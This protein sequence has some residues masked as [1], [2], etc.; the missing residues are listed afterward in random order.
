[1]DKI[2]S[3]NDKAKELGFKNFREMINGLAARKG[4]VI[5]SDICEENVF[6]RIDFGRWIA[7]CGCGAANY[8]EPVDPVYFCASCGNA[9][10]GGKLRKVSFPKNRIEIETELLTREVFVNLKLKPV[11]GAINAISAAPGIARSW[12][13]GETIELLKKQKTETKN[14]E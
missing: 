5:S 11:D 14:G 13:P 4:F 8:V 3:G 7:D 2:F 10:S 9:V 1:M 12:S 6:A